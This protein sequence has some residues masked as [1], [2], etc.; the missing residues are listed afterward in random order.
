MLKL[1]CLSLKLG[2]PLSG[3]NLADLEGSELTGVDLLG[4]EG[5]PLG[6]LSLV[7]DTLGYLLSL[8]YEYVIKVG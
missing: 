8:L 5:F 7:S 1:S 6:G 2:S 4:L 3:L